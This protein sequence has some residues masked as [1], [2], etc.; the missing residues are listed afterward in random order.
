MLELPLYQ[1]RLN[2][3]FLIAC[4]ALGG[5]S[6]VP[7]Q[8]AEQVILKY[9]IL[10]ESVSVSE[11][12]ALA[13]TGEVSSSLESYLKLAQK[14]PED[15]QK[16]LSQKVEVNPVLLSQLLNSSPGEFL[17][18][19]VS[20]VIH[21]PSERANRQALRGALVSSALPDGNIRLIEVLENYP[22]AE[23]HV[24]GDRLAEIY[25]Q[26]KKLLGSLPRLPL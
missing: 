20:E 12:G 3:N 4:C 22:T 11:L 15:L 9:S 21:T 2:L 19:R 7:V 6:A 17:L 13:E 24:E 10:R 16:I 26:F 1:S 14:K 23:V 5:L 18:D 8:A 25:G